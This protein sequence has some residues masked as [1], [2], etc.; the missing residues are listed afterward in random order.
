MTRVFSITSPAPKGGVEFKQVDIEYDQMPV[1]LKPLYTGICGTDRGIVGGA[2]PFAY[3][4]DGYSELVLGHES[5]CRVLSVAD[6]EFGISRGDIV[7]PQVRRPGSCL[8]CISGRSDNCSDGDKHE[9]GVTGM[10]GFMREEFGDMPEFLIKVNSSSISDLAVLTEPLKN[11]EKAFESLQVALSRSISTNKSGSYE[12]KRALIIGTG[13][14]AFLYSLKCRDFAFDTFITNRHGVDENKLKFFEKSGT[15]FFDYTRDR[16]VKPGWDLVI[17]TSGDPGT[18]IRFLRDM[19]NNGNLILFGTNGKSPKSSLDGYD[20]SHIVEKNIFILGSV[21]GARMHYAQ[22][23]HD[24]ELW[25]SVY[26]DSVRS[27]L[28]GKFRPEDTGIVADKS[29]GEIKS[30]IDWSR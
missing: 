8:N 1:I 7:V 6:N 22:A 14:E 19:N 16:D 29:E 5:V 2:L 24:L 17:D 21:D 10:H 11:V 30:I 25:S 20:I 15:R 23:I 13:S 18:I 3:P 4:P 9:A 27:M 28:T 12:G 26:G